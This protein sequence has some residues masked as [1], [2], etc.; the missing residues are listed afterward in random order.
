VA[1]AAAWT[2][3]CHYVMDYW[4][5]WQSSLSVCLRSFLLPIDL[6]HKSNNLN[7]KEPKLCFVS[8]PE[9]WGGDGGEVL[10]TFATGLMIGC[11]LLKMD[12]EETNSFSGTIVHL[13]LK[14]SKSL[15]IG[16]A[17]PLKEGNPQDRVFHHQCR[18]R[19]L[20]KKYPVVRA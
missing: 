5:S 3:D 4:G 20:I 7:P 11:L 16:V 8:P 17:S 13:D 2:C 1:K 15:F 14:G 12:M 10:G 18:K 19:L 9:E 6:L